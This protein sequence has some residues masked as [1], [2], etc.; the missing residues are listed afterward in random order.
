MDNFSAVTLPP[1]PM[2]GISIPPFPWISVVDVKS[3]S[4]LCNYDYYV[5]M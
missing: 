2:F 1:Q 3:P 4:H 5:I